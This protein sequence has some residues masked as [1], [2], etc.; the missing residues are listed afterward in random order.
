MNQ[1]VSPLVIAEQ[2]L[3]LRREIDTTP[4][5]ALKLVYMCHGWMLG[6]ESEPLISESVEAWT[7]GPVIPAVYHRYKQ[8]GGEI[9]LE[10]KKVADQSE[11][12]NAAMNETVKNVE[13]VYRECTAYQLSA[14]THQPGTPWDITR[15]ENGI[16]SVIPNELIEKHYR[17]M[18]AR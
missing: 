4:M 11:K 1:S 14:L 9:I 7:Y 8:Y 10:Q 2:I 6:F 3:W 12:L 5:H 15:R 13:S 16:G 18:L 17:D